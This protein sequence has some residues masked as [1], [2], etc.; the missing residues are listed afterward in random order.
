MRY[1]LERIILPAVMLTFLCLPA[2]KAYPEMYV[3]GQA[4]WTFPQALSNVEGTGALSG[5]SLSDFALQSSLLYGA[6]IG[7]YFPTFNWLG[8]EAEVFNSTP[9]IKQQSGTAQGFGA[10]VPYVLPGSHLRVL[11]T[12]LNLL[13]R[14]PG[15]RF[16][17]YLGLGLGVFFVRANDASGSSSDN[18][19]PGLNALVGARLFVT[20]RLAV[21]VEGKYNRATFQLDTAELKGDY[22]AVH[23]VVGLALHFDSFRQH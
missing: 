13:A 22:S 6:K 12:A 4:G 8:V 3:A 21:F 18:G 14:Y 17:P 11:T 19:V 2:G 5:F 16:Q 15:E 23:G 20:D 10:S 1:R 7:Y 9:N